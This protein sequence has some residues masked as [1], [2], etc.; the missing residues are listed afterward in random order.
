MMFGFVFIPPAENANPGGRMAF[1]SG[2]FARLCKK[3]P[4]VTLNNENG[5]G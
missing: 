3:E 1:L 5:L 4:L 2:L